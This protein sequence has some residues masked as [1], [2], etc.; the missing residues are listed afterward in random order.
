MSIQSAAV[1]H[2]ALK[3][4]AALLRA[5]AEGMQRDDVNAR[6]NVASSALVVFI[7]QTVAD[8]FSK[9]ADQILPEVDPTKT[10]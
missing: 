9:L 7:K 10:V 4:R 3:T 8:E 1:V 5:E 2:A 6:S